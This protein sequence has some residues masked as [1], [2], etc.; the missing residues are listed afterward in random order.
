[1][2][3]RSDV[4]AL[5]DE[6]TVSLAKAHDHLAYSQG[7]WL[8]L[9]ARRGGRYHRSRVVLANPVTGQAVLGNEL[10]SVVTE[11]VELNLPSAAVQ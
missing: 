6:V 8:D 9:L 11:S 2:S 10:R 4:V 7:L 5:R 3:L 1:M